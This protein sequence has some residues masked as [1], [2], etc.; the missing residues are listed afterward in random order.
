MAA[1]RIS[2][3]EGWQSV[4]IRKIANEIEYS[5]PT[6]YEHFSNKEEMMH[7]LVSEGFRQL[8]EKLRHAYLKADNPESGFMSLGKAYLEFVQESKELYEVMHGLGTIKFGTDK[9]PASAKETFAFMR[10][11]VKDLFV[12]KS[13]EE[14][15]IDDEV[16]IVWS[17][18]H[19]LISLSAAHRIAGDTS[20][21]ERLLH[22]T[23]AN[24]LVLWSM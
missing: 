11:V 16:D 20:R 22:K 6:I 17:S 5:P 18:L 7:E 1:R 10:S 19:G 4:T 12:Y 21:F 23:L 15:N 14:I 8:L 3:Q 13:W 2:A 24:F 9:T